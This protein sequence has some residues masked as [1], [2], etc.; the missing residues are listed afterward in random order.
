[1]NRPTAL[2]GGL[3]GVAP[4]DQIGRSGGGEALGLTPLPIDT[5]GRSPRAG[6]AAEQRRCWRTDGRSSEGNAPLGLPIA[7]AWTGGAI[8]AKAIRAAARRERR[9]SVIATGPSV[10]RATPLGRTIIRSP[11]AFPIPAAV[12]GTVAPGF[13]ALAV[14]GGIGPA[15]GTLR[16]T[17]AGLGPETPT[18][19]VTVTV[20]TGLRPRR[21][22]SGGPAA[23]PAEGSVGGRSP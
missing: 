19:T 3:G 8:G 12:R 22:R 5:G 14:A 13:E 11:A 21:T 2:E 4:P 23:G 18:L 15:L 10:G 6:S 7:E 9:T 20:A 17:G 1:V 16:T